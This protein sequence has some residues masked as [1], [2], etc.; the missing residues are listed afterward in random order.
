VNDEITI[1]V[2]MDPQRTVTGVYIQQH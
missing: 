1:A 2:F